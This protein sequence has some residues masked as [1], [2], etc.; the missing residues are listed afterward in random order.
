MGDKSEEKWIVGD[1]S[2]GKATFSEHN[3]LLGL[4]GFLFAHCFQR[5]NFFLFRR[6]QKD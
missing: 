4:F 2:L 1:E 3:A 5:L 6:S